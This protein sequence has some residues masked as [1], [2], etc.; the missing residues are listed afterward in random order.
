METRDDSY[1]KR[2][3]RRRRARRVAAAD[4]MS[5]TDRARLGGDRA[6]AAEVVRRALGHVASSGEALSDDGSGFR[7]EDRYEEMA[8]R[9]LASFGGLAEESARHVEAILLRACSTD[10]FWRVAAGMAA[11]LN[12]GG[13]ADPA[14]AAD[15][16]PLPAGMFPEANRVEMSD[17]HT[18]VVIGP[19]FATDTLSFTVYP[20]HGGRRGSHPIRM[21]ISELMRRSGSGS[22]N[23]I[24]SWEGRTLVF[25]SGGSMVRFEHDDLLGMWPGPAPDRGSVEGWTVLS[26]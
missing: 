1:H 24:S 8:G 13:D 19:L 9:V 22:A 20:L 4:P 14:A 11:R 15:E 5:A 3:L 21:P 17:P 7:S 18:Q 10:A 23:W 6:V 16:V 2:A 12:E 26:D 25:S